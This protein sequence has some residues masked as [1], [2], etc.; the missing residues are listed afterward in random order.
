M[1]TK[2]NIPV[3]RLL[4]PELPRNPLNS[5]TQAQA[6][7][8]YTQSKAL[9]SGKHSQNNAPKVFM[10]VNVNLSFWGITKSNRRWHFQIQY[11]YLPVEI[12][13][14]RRVLHIPRDT[15]LVFPFWHLQ[16]R[17]LT[18][19]VTTLLVHT[20]GQKKHFWATKINTTA[21]RP[22]P[23]IRASLLL[24]RLLQRGPNFGKRL[25]SD[26]QTSHGSSWG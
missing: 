14:L 22:L 6:A 13:V 20:L 25:E 2:T 8:N 15:Y 23:E 16:E 9:Q 24:S 10:S 19:A 1:M 11:T 7:I 17:L 21:S 5:Q 12:W 18:Q 3:H 26:P 4:R